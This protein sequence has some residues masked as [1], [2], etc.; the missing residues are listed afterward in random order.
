[1]KHN[2]THLLIESIHK[3]NTSFSATS[4]VVQKRTT[5]LL[6]LA[7]FFLAPA[8][9]YAQDF[10]VDGIVDVLDIDDD[11]DGILDINEI[12]SSLDTDADD[13]GIL[14][15]REA[16]STAGFQAPLGSD[17]DGDGL[18]NRY[19]LTP[20][21]GAGGS[22]GLTPVN[23]DGAAPADFRDIDSD[24]DGILDSVE[25][26]VDQGA[27][28]ADTEWNFRDTDSDGDAITD[29]VEAQTTAGFV[30]PGGT[31]TDGDGLDN[32][33]DLAVGIPGS[34]GLTP[35]NTDGADA[36]DYVDLDSDNDGVTDATEGNTDSALDTDTVSNYRDLDSDG[37]GIIDGTDGVADSVL[38]AD[39]L[40]NYLDTDSDGDGITDNVEAQTTAGF[41]APS[42]SDTDGD[43]LDNAYDVAVGFA[44]S[45][46]LTPVNTDGADTNDYVD[47]DSDN[48]AINDSVEGTTDSDGDGTSNYRDTDSDN[49]GINDSVEGSA[50]SALDTDLIPNYLDLDSD[51]DGI[52]DG[53]DGATDS[54]ADADVLVNYL[55]TDS[56]GDGISDTVE[57]QDT[58]GALI[59]SGSDTDSD[60]L[61]NNFDAS[62][63]TGYAGS[64]LITPVNTD[65]IDTNDYVD[66]DSDNDGV[67]DATEGNTDSALDVDTIPNYRDLDADGDGIP[68][69]VE[70]QATN[71]Y[72]VP[73]YLDGDGDGL[74]NSYEPNGITPVNND[75]DTFADMLDANSDADGGVDALESG[76]TLTGTT[77]ANGLDSGAGI[78]G[79]TDVNGN[80]HNGTNFLLT[81]TN[82][83]LLTNGSNAV[84]YSVDF[85][86]RVGADTDNDG[87]ADT[88]D[89]DDDNDGI[90]DTTESFNYA[91]SGTASMNSTFPGGYNAS[92]AIDGNTAG[93]PAVNFAVTNGAT[94]TD[95]W[96]VDLGAN[97]L[98]NT[99]K[100]F[101]R[102][103]CCQDRLGNVYVMISDTPFPADPLNLAG[104]LANADFTYQLPAVVTGDFN[105]PVP[106]VSGRYVRLQKSGTNPGGNF[107]NIAEVQAFSSRD[108]D[109]DGILNVRDIDSDN[110]GIPDN[111]EAQ[112]S[113]SYNDPNPDSNANYQTN[114]GVNSAYI[115]GLTPI[116]TDGNDSADYIDIDSDNDTILDINES[117]ITAIPLVLADADNDGLQDVFDTVVNNIFNINTNSNENITSFASSFLT[118]IVNPGGLFDFR[119]AID[120]DSDGVIDT[121]DIDDDNDGIIDSQEVL[122]GQQFIN[123]ALS[124]TATQSSTL[125]GFAAGFGN[126]GNTAGSNGGG[127][128]A[129]TL[130]LTNTDYWQVDLGAN[131]LI[132]TVN[133][134]NRDDCCI[135][136]LGNVYVLISDTPFPAD[137][138]DLAGS[139]ANA[140]F[141]Y[142]LPT[143]LV[144][145]TGDLTISVP[146]VS[147]R[148]VRLQKSGLNPSGNAI[149]IA[150]VQVL[151][152]A[153]NYALSGTATQNSTNGGGGF[154]ANFANNGIIAGS[155]VTTAHTAGLTSTDYW[156]VTLVNTAPINSI[157]IWNRDD[158]C[159]DRLGNVYL[160]VADTP[161]P[162]D[163]A[164]SLT[165]ADFTFQL[166]A[167][168]TGDL[169]VPVPNVIGKY[170]RLQKSGTNP[171]G[172]ALNIAEVGVFGDNSILD[173]DN[174]GYLNSV[175]IDSDND[176]IPDNIEAQN[177][178]QY[179]LSDYID[180]DADGLL[181]R[182]DITPGSG[183]AG[184]IGLIPLNTDATD[185]SDFLDTDTDNDGTLDINENGKAGPI[186]SADS[187]RDGLDDG[188][189]T[190]ATLGLPF[191]VNDNIND[192]RTDVLPDIDQDLFLGKDLD[193][194]DAI[195]DALLDADLDGVID[196]RDSDDDNDGVTDLAE[197][198]NPSVTSV[199]QNGGF[200][201]LT[202]P[203]TFPLSPKSI[204]PNWNTNNPSNN[205]EVWQNIHRNSYFSASPVVAVQNG[206]NA[207]ELNSDASSEL[208]QDIPTT[209]G[210][211]VNW[212]F[213]HVAREV[214]N[215]V[216]P[217]KDAMIVEFGPPAG[218]MVTQLVAISDH[219]S[220]QLKQGTYVIPA[221][222]TTTRFQFR[223]LYTNAGN[224]SVGNLID[225]ISFNVRSCS[226]TDGDAKTDYF[227][228]DSDNDGIP[229]NIE[230]QT[231][232]GYVAPGTFTDGDNDGLNDVYDVSQGGTTLS[233]LL[234]SDADTVRDAIDLDTDNDGI[235]DN[236]EGFATNLY[237][238]PG[239][240]NPVTGSVY[241]TMANPPVNSDGVA[242]TPDYRDTDSDNDGRLDINEAYTSVT[243]SGPVGVN[244]LF[245]NVESAD[246]YS[247]TNGNAFGLGIFGLK[248]LD[249]DT[250]P[251]GSNATPP[252]IDFEYRD[253][254]N[255]TPFMRNGKFFFN[256]ILQPARF[257]K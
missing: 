114:L 126:D 97:A 65:G 222:Q 53:L 179:F 207:M 200:D 82:P 151:E 31:D 36:T 128:M 44:G 180:S 183:A 127:N 54:V 79:F 184:S 122:G 56:D 76:L 141:T 16:Q 78:A 221:G 119:Q 158:C 101:N 247:D 174:D 12:A 235:P 84:P 175:D 165:N 248:D 148:Y 135:D 68:D 146:N 61:D 94:T 3:L 71:A 24:G 18:D 111:L 191:D 5:L 169:I 123:Y 252:T 245:N 28:D 201:I 190:V 67:A 173:F 156:Q 4:L 108:S 85:N 59:A 99:V 246:N 139:L 216:T 199:L 33:Y 168:V 227:D 208:F 58:V 172:P 41:V 100:I 43:G 176:G 187:D 231:T 9:S 89:Q 223:A 204:L 189:D 51:G 228:L 118:D 92:F 214:S 182:Y 162:A 157:K 170:V 72:I 153:P 37:D 15:N 6:L 17:T 113:A 237:V 8:V 188:Y 251:N 48:D 163:L 102:D 166:P 69:N 160:M 181:Q 120:S 115:G 239:A 150:E 202:G 104:S 257:G 229:D 142:Q 220:W 27:P 20:A 96:Q 140:D 22:V 14:D 161:F 143:V 23:T 21:G 167:V 49:D 2:I 91:L 25:G 66:L 105:V 185:L 234:D 50:D 90:L 38:D 80:A 241:V 125:G 159:Q 154:S 134:F 149:N 131:A 93:G 86:Y 152:N 230:H 7:L 77:Q 186:A 254:Y 224:T 83:I 226:D 233:G 13:D 225:N 145:G 81:S 219:L 46:G 244:G 74:M 132:S 70:A 194:R 212:S 147:G 253:N 64:N 196:A 197:C 19:D 98:I 206:T 110:D 133:I 117:R 35:V 249:S 256:G 124:G 87:L 40:V 193:Y 178:L 215:G 210:D 203:I 116:N 45:A 130:G 95:F 136:R 106:N 103:D 42:G 11:A 242:N 213:Y 60:G 137:P 88:L 121:T 205:V 112:T 238:A 30:A 32:V 39:V 240:V 198:P 255:Y 195:L 217:F 26:L 129:H 109:L 144:S 218:P 10:D 63:N 34:S 55:D 209:P 57:A 177:T 236:V 155:G 52:I 211:L 62:P 243:P 138:L 75:G 171:G 164:G 232:A 47:L 73:N 1:M 250:L 192:P 107:I 29:N